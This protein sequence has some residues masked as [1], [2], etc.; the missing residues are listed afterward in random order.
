MS[1]GK[2]I[3]ETERK[4]I[5]FGVRLQLIRRKND[6]IKNLING[7]YFLARCNS[8]AEQLHPKGKIEEKLDG[9]LKTREYLLS[10]YALVKMQA[11]VGMRGAH[12]AKKDL[13]KDFNLTEK[14]IEDIED[15][16]YNGKIIREDYD[17]SY[18]KRTK[19]EFVN[20]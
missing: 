11:I 5:A 10:E 6:Y 20:T 16:Y 15:D 17:E 1:K 14:E 8:I 12:F 3:T 18:K 4:E 9:R 2:K 19:A 7:R 13:I